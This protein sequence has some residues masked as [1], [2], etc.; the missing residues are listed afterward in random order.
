MLLRFGNGL[1]PSRFDFFA[2]RFADGWFE[3][4][5][6]FPN[7]GSFFGAASAE[8]LC[9]NAHSRAEGGAVVL[10]DD[11]VVKRF[12]GGAI[13]QDDGLALGL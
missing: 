9:C 13:P 7:T 5:I 6:N 10:P 3:C 12:A 11:G 1:G 8:S 2:G 4:S